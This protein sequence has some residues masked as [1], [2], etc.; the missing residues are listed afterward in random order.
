MTFQTIPLSQLPK[1]RS[2]SYDADKANALLA[3]LET[4]EA[5][6]DAIAYATE[7]EARAV[8]A[9]TKRL[10]SHVAPDGKV[11][12]TAVG[13]HPDGSGFAW[14]LYLSEPTAANGKRK[15]K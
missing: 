15:S 11:L 9:A 12:R 6:S 7:Q 3:G 5:V 14:Y 1:R 2:R 4:G 13:E 8:A 10:A